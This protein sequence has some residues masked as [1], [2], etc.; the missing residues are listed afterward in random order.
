MSIYPNKARK[1]IKVGIGMGE[2]LGQEKLSLFSL[3]LRAWSNDMSKPN[4]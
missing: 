4:T 1:K 2:N 3:D